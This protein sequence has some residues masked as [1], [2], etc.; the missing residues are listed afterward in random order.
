MYETAVRTQETYIDLELCEAD[1]TAYQSSLI[2]DDLAR[3]KELEEALWFTGLDDKPFPE[4]V[5][6]ECGRYAGRVDGARGGDRGL[7]SGHR[8]TWRR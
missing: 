2:L 6:G 5:C 7:R 4:L 1:T 3:F 8:C